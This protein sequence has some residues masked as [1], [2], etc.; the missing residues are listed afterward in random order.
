MIKKFG[1]LAE[2][3][4]LHYNRKNVMY[5]ALVIGFSLSEQKINIEGRDSDAQFNA[6][7]FH[8]FSFRK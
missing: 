6:I 4:L 8:V 7:H 3:N 1:I 2:K 5:K